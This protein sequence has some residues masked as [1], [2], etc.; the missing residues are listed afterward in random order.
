MKYK[1][2]TIYYKTSRESDT[3]KKLAKIE[4][5]KN[6][7]I[8]A[9]KAL[10][11]KYPYIKEFQQGYWLVWGG[12]SAIRFKDDYVVDKKLWKKADGSVGYMPRKGNPINK[13]IDDLPRV[14]ISDLNLCVGFEENMVK[15]IGVGFWENTIGVCI[16]CDWGI[17]M[18]DDC[19]E[20][21]YTQYHDKD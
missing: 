2:E 19:K 8:G 7:A 9:L 4:S 6:D 1:S 15:T 5:Q 10:L 12:V 18:P 14:H 17:K 20:V 21:T 11:K 16:G 13:E 3:G